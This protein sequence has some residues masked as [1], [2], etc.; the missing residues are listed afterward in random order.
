MNRANKTNY[1][2]YCG[3][4]ILYIFHL[5]LSLIYYETQTIHVTYDIQYNRLNSK[6]NFSN[7]LNGSLWNQEAIYTII[8][9]LFGKVE[10]NNRSGWISIIKIK[11]RINKY[12]DV[13]I[14]IYISSSDS[15]THMYLYRA[16]WYDIYVVRKNPQMLEDIT[17]SHLVTR[18]NLI[19][20]IQ[21]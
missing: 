14:F 8:I 1:L 2:V 17:N 15:R 5:M 13:Q 21:A 9:N 6:S 4:N 12:M 7:L 16:S 11:L 10:E 20:I 3:T 18:D 19:G